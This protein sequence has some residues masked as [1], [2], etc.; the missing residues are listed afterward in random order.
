MRTSS[1][2]RQ[3]RLCNSNVRNTGLIPGGG[4]TIPNAIWQ[5]QNKQKTETNLKTWLLKKKQQPGYYSIDYCYRKFG[6][7]INV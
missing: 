2:V 4:I 3:L 6:T 5:G 7:H 1:E